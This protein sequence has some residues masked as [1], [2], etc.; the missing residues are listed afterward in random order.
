MVR[1]RGAFACGVRYISYKYN[2]KTLLYL[3]NV[4]YQRVD[5]ISEWI[6]FYYLAPTI[7]K[8]NNTTLGT[9]DNYIRNS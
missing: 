4:S 1:F 9:N 7:L 5:H 8:Y 2:Y 6:N 3:Y